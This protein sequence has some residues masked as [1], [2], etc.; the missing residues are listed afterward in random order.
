[1][2]ST[3]GQR[4]TND[5]RPKGTPWAARLAVAA[6][7]VFAVVDVFDTIVAVGDYE[8]WITVV[9]HGEPDVQAAYLLRELL[10]HVVDKMEGPL[11]YPDA[12]G[13][14]RSVV[15]T[16]ALLLTVAAVS[17]WLYRA[18]GTVR[19]K[20]ALLGWLGVT[21]LLKLVIAVY[22]RVAAPPD[23][24]VDGALATRSVAYPLWTAATIALVVTAVLAIRTIRRT[25]HTR[26]S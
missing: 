10:D 19:P 11:I 14:A 23:P 1:V 4:P 25:N 21:V 5:V 8:Y 2:E 13:T 12:V 6:L 20:R 22:D 17:V 15:W 24:S 26:R 3:L 16:L 7:A 9:T 18:W